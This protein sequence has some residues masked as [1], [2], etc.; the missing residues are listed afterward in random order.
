MCIYAF[1]VLLNIFYFCISE[2]RI[3]WYW[4]NYEFMVDLWETRLTR[5]Y[6]LYM[7]WI[8]INIVFCS[9]ILLLMLNYFV[10][11]GIELLYL[12]NMLLAMISSC[13][14]IAAT[15]IFRQTLML[16]S[17]IS[18]YCP[19]YRL[20]CWL[21]YYNWLTDLLFDLIPS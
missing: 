10:M 9:N 18:A 5:L 17:I 8:S 1:N 20:I 13:I 4:I 12:C 2:I 7:Q 15:R 19:T 11:L 14:C 3:N 6:I 21:T 16:W